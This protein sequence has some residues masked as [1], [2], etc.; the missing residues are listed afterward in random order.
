MHSNIEKTIANKKTNQESDIMRKII[1]NILRKIFYQKYYNWWDGL[2]GYLLNNSNVELTKKE[3]QEIDKF[4]SRFTNLKL[5][6]TFYKTAKKFD[7]FDINYIQDT[8]YFSYILRHLNPYEVS[9]TFSNKCFYGFHFNQ[10]NRPFEPVRNINGFWYNSLNKQISKEEAIDSL[11]EYNKEIIVKPT[12]QTGGGRGIEFFKNYDKGII[13]TIFSKFNKD[14]VIQ[15]LVKQSEKT[16][17]FNPTSLNCFRITTLMLNGKFSVLSRT[18]KTGA[19][20]AKIDNIGTKGEGGII[21]GIDAEGQ[22]NKYGIT[23]DGRKTELSSCGEI[24]EKHCLHNEIIKIDK[25]TEELHKHCPFCAIIG[26]DICL[27]EYDNPLLIE[28]NLLEPGILYEQLCTGPIFGERTEEVL[29]YVTRNGAINM[30][31]KHFKK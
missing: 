26:W 18:L 2:R 9:K 5:G 3:K 29:N 15:G 27:D 12:A 10:F 13:E 1:E 21:V 14:F 31:I 16:S 6:Y 11:L 20:D 24:F 4:H 30:W 28:V 17:I 22:L 19:K 8:L 23:K 25:F 7:K